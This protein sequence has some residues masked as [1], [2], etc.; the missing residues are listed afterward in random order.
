TNDDGEI[1]DSYITIY[2]KE[3]KKLKTV[4]AMDPNVE[5][6]LYPIFFPKGEHIWHPDLKKLNSNQRLTRSA[7]VKYM[8]SIRDGE[9]NA[10]LHGGRLFQQWLVDTALKILKDRVNYLK[11]HQ[12]KL[13]RDSYATINEFVQRFA[14][15][16]NVQRIGAKY[17]LP[18]SH[19]GS[20]R[21]MEQLYQDAMAIVRR[22][23]KPDLF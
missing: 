5:P 16:N 11:T 22:F 14:Q 10:V 17:I 20:P 13:L 6:W 1:P 9:F 12:E 3:Q 21:N 15:D 23:G 18:S 4:N 2:D 8:I 19:P 7:Y